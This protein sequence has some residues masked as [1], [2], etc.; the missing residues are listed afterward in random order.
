M[1]GLTGDGLAPRTVQYVHAVLRTALAQ[2]VRDD[3]VGRNMASV[4]RAPRQVRRE[5]AYL[6]VGESRRLIDAAMGS[7]LE[8]VVVVALTLGLRRGELLGLRWSAVDLNASRLR[9]VS[10]VQRVS[11]RLAIEEPKT[12]SSVRTLPLPGSTVA[13]LREHRA[14]N[15]SARRRPEVA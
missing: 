8:A 10:T 5:A 4:G 6:S 14:G 9:V 11:G 2:A 12:R 15:S 3:L 1:R 13:A 7:A